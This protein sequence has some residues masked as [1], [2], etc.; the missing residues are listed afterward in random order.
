MLTSVILIGDENRRDEFKSK[1]PD[2]KLEF[3][4]QN[5][6][7][8]SLLEKASLVFDLNLDDFPDRIGLYEAFPDL[9]VVASAVKVSLAEMVY[10]LGDDFEGALIGINS[11]PSFLN[12]PRLEFSLY[13]ESDRDKLDT[14]CKALNT[15][16]DLVKDRVGMIVPRILFMIINEACIVLQ[17]GTATIKDVDQAMQLGTNYPGGPFTWADNIGLMNVY[18]TLVSMQEDTGQGRYKVAPLLKEY[19]LKGKRFY[20]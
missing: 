2:L 17:E 3:E 6:E 16:Y 9:I 7:D 15:E 10:G 20:S 8:F 1:F 13:H 11:L 5:L 19:A 12:R 14:L 4:G 18:E